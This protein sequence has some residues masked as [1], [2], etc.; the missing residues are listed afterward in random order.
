VACSFRLR[1]RCDRLGRF[2]VNGLKMMWLVDFVSGSA[3]WAPCKSSFRRSI[4]TSLPGFT[5]IPSR[6]MQME[7]EPA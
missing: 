5:T 6:C 1:N 2:A 4:R 3:C 7:D